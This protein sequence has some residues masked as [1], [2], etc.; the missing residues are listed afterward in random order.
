MKKMKNYELCE[1]DD[2]QGLF[3]SYNNVTTMYGGVV[4][5]VAHRKN[6]F[7]VVVDDHQ[8]PVVYHCDVWIDDDD[9]DYGDGGV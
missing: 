9:G 2:D 7:H 6:W 8:H 3:L 5:A 1:C 4:V